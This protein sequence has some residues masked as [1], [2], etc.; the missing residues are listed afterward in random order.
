MF[1]SDIEYWN[2]KLK[3]LKNSIEKLELIEE[4]YQQTKPKEKK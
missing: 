1:A 4:I 2:W 3:K